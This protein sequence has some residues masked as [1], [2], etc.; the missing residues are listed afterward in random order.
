MVPCPVAGERPSCVGSACTYRP[1]SAVL[2]RPQ[3]RTWAAFDLGEAHSGLLSWSWKK[4]ARSVSR[5]LDDNLTTQV[6]S[7]A[8]WAWLLRLGSELAAGQH[9][10]SL[11]PRPSALWKVDPGSLPP[12]RN[13]TGTGTPVWMAAERSPP[14]QS[15]ASLLGWP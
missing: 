2:Q 4:E 6:S 14:L 7:A 12:V 1:A 8:S 15:L 11:H 5:H 3:I 13:R 10:G 9:Q